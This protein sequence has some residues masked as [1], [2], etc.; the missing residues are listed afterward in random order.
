M[1]TSV[2]LIPPWDQGD[3]N[4]AYALASA[5]PGH[6]FRV[7]TTCDGLA[8]T[9]ANLEPEPVYYSRHPSLGQK[10]RVYW[11]LLDFGIRN[12]GF[13]LRRTNSPIPNPQSEIDLY[14]LIYR[15]YAL[16][17][18]LCR[19]V[20][21]FR[22]RPTLHTVPATADGR[23]LGRHLFF[24]HRLVVLSQHGR[25]TLRRLG[26]TNVVHIPPG[27]EITPWAALHEQKSQLKAR[28]GLADHPVLLF[29]GHFSPGYGADVMLAALPLIVAQ[30]P[31]VRVIFAC[32]LRS[33]GDRERERAARQMV[34]RMG[35]TETVRFYN[36]VADMRPLIGS[37]DLTVLP[38]ETMRDKV[39]IPI[40]LLESLAAGRPVVIS[41]LPP[42]N[43][44]LGSGGTQEQRSGGARVSEVGVAVPPGDAEAL[45]QAVVDLLQD[46]G[47]RER[48]GRRGQEL[49]RDNFDIR[50]VAQQYEKLYQEMIR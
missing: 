33:P 49:V 36:T 23:P 10:A 20:P 5:L 43:E 14:H 31:G 42:M 2:P 39:D 13:R 26:L 41:D 7:L 35:L 38:L 19:L 3:K 29:P 25:Q 22:R 18:W 46:A 47:Q 6:R 16:S 28:M 30:V 15:P 34:A 27:I 1:I 8:P 4:L 11:R 45:A 37:S 9:A 48:M 12:S 17:S 50:Q 44:L 21:E 24:A 40:T 32:R